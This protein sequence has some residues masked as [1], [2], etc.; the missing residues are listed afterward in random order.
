MPS[1][2]AGTSFR[3]PDE[4]V[5]QLTEICLAKD[6]LSRTRVVELAIAAYHRDV[7]APA[8]KRPRTIKESKS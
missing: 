4:T 8:P 7:T 2:K 6:G 1:T 5:Q 3:L